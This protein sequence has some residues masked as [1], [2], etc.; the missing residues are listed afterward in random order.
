MDF[1]SAPI[2]IFT[3]S[4]HHAPRCGTPCPVSGDN[5]R[6]YPGYFENRHG[7]QAVFVF[8]DDTGKGRL[9]L[10]DAG[11]EAWHPVVDGLRNR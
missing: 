1:E 6:A 4:N 7:E 10:G 3:V 5:E 9:A 2:A 11:W 8:D